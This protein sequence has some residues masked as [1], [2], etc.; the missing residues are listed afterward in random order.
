VTVGAF[1]DVV[2]V[3]HC[4]AYTL[5]FRLKAIDWIRERLRP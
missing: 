2:V 5:S 1:T 4:S 3:A